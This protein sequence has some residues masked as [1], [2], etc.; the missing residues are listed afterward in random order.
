MSTA[1]SP[2][3]TKISATTSPFP[4][5]FRTR[6]G[7]TNWGAGRETTEEG[8]AKLDGSRTASPAPHGPR[9]SQIIFDEGS[10][11]SVGAPSGLLDQSLPRAIGKISVEDVDAEYKQFI[12]VYVEKTK[13]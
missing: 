4:K 2:K 5:E 7:L 12:V 1:P 11:P 9:L 8:G 6:K 10:L 13:G 3:G